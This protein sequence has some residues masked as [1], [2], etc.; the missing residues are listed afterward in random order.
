M[1]DKQKIRIWAG[2]RKLLPMEKLATSYHYR[3]ALGEGYLRIM[4][5]ASRAQVA[6]G[7]E[8]SIPGE[9]IAILTA[10]QTILIEL[11]T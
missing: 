4:R 5:S 11:I 3:C 8:F 1:E 9:D 7:D 2:E 6:Q 10:K